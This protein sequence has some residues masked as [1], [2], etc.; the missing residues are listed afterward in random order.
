MVREWPRFEFYF[1]RIISEFIDHGVGVSYFPDDL[2]W[3]PEAAGLEDFKIPR[4]TPATEDAIDVAVCHVPLRINALYNSIR[5]PEAA[6]SAGW[7]V[8]QARELI[9]DALNDDHED[10]LEDTFT[11]WEAVESRI[12]NNDIY[13]THCKAK[14]IDVIHGWVQEQDGTVTHL[15]V[16]KKG[17]EDK[18]F[19]FERCARF[20][21][22]H[23][24][25]T[26][27]TYGIG[28]GFYHGIRGLGFKI[29]PHI[30]VSNRLRCAAVDGAILSSAVMVQPVDQSARALEDLSLTY[31]GPW[32]LFPPGLKVVERS[33][34]NFATSV[35]P[36]IND[37]SVQ[38]Q[39]NTG[40]YQS[41]A[42]TPEGQARTAYEVRAQLQKEA[43][44]SASAVNLFYG[45][46]SR[47][48]REMFRRA[49]NPDLTAKDPGGRDAYEFRRRIKARGVPL[50]ALYE[51]FRVDAIRS[52]GFGS[53]SM[54][55]VALD[56]AMQLA[57]SMDEYGRQ[58]LVR[59]RLAAR[60]GYD[61]V[62]RYVPRPQM[63]LRQ[64]IDTKIA[65]LENQALSQ[66]KPITVVPNENHFIHANAVLN[67]LA[68]TLN[69]TQQGQ[70]DLPTALGVFN[71]ALPHA[72]AH[73][74]PLSKD[75]IH[76]Q[77]AAGMR[78]ALNNIGAM[79]QRMA[80]EF[81]AQ[82]ENAA[83]AQ[84]AD[85]QRQ[86][87]AQ[88]AYVRDLEERAQVSPEMAA[89]LK[90]M[91]MKMELD[92]AKAT[93]DIQIKQA[94]AAQDL[95]MRDAKEASALLKESARPTMGAINAPSTQQGLKA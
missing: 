73:V 18:K 72:A 38:L 29:L 55:M 2:D 52:I 41:R 15:M 16:P 54:R 87:D 30:Q 57:P 78:Q 8:T 12:K 94:K 56:E 60:F 7:D 77:A 26:I 5:D 14:K 31:Y 35:L 24:A 79:G 1:Q 84:Q 13:W 37:L 62:D 76:S 63:Q 48:L 51:V 91:A 50:D 9:R 59:D 93:T 92:A 47:V 58:N 86:A 6:A 90:A 65:E 74:E 45:P 19:L 3:R 22:I 23:Q 44:L 28:N 40:S 53:A 20:A 4:G 82:Q 25:F 61:T 81:Q 17:D 39:N 32:A 64:P 83:K 71:V 85:Q 10:K 33:V 70:M 21:S 42:T 80:A 88:A 27:F 89:K 69:A 11:D 46:W 68:D 66:G 34:P 43:V 95:A 49:K 67:L 36:V 75:P